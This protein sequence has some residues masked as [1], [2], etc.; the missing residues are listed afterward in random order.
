[1]SSIESPKFYISKSPQPM[2]VIT[3][4]LRSYSPDFSNINND[5]KDNENSP[6]YNNRQKKSPNSQASKFSKSEVRRVP[7]MLI[8]EMDEF[9][10]TF[11][12]KGK[13]ENGNSSPHEL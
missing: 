6:I 3:K 7:T 9:E 13:D 5:S 12:K 4:N 1:M 11:H 10:L 2:N 8:Q